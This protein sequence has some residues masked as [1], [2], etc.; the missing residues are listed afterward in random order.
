MALSGTMRAVPSRPNVP[1][2]SSGSHPQGLEVEIVHVAVESHIVYSSCHRARE[3][4][5]EGGV[6]VERQ[7]ASLYLSVGERG[8]CLEVGI[9]LLV[10]HNRG[11]IGFGL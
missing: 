11:H 4:E 10:E 8:P 6:V 9:C 2:H 5:V 3:V 1:R 7:Q